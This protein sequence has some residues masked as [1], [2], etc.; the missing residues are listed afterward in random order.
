MLPALFYYRSDF[1]PDSM[2]IN[3]CLCEYTGPVME[4]RGRG[5]VPGAWH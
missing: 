1:I 5:T 3:G 2:K 4:I